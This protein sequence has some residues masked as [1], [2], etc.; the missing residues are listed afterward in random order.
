MS[1]AVHSTSHAANVFCSQQ[2]KTCM[3]MSFKIVFSPCYDNGW[4]AKKLSAMR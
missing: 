4:M 2:P 3:D 1:M